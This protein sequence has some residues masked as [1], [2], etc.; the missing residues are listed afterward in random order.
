MKIKEILKDYPEDYNL[1]IGAKDG[2]GY[3]YCGTVGDWL[4]NGDSYSDTLKENIR[5]KL[6]KYKNT[7]ESL[8]LN[9]CKDILKDSESGHI[10]TGNYSETLEAQIL[11]I[12]RGINT[13]NNAKKRLNSYVRI[14]DREVVETFEADLAVEYPECLTI[15]V[16]GT[17]SGKYWCTEE[18]DGGHIG[19]N[20]AA[21]NALMG[22]MGV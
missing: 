3:F 19:I 1:K 21:E 18:H 10:T 8:I 22:M 20:T 17:E 4:Q 5:T 12:S 2:N 13:K 11:N 7:C 9:F 15:L 6:I 16:K 14:N